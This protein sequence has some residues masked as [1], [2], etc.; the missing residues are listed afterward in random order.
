MLGYYSSLN[1]SV[2]RWQ[3][4]EAEAAGLSFFIVS[5]WGP[6]GSNRDDNEINRAALNFFSVLA[7]MHTRFKAAIMIDA[8]NDS[9]G[10]L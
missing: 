5:W 3:V 9:L 8:Y 2:V 1:D 7:S 10:Y 6:L 4:S